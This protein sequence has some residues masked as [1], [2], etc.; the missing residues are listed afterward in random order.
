M[1]QKLQLLEDIFVQLNENQ[2]VADRTEFITDW[3]EREE[4]Y[5]RVLRSKNRDP[6]DTIFLNCADVLDRYAAAYQSSRIKSVRDVGDQLEVL[7]K[8]CKSI[9]DQGKIDQSTARPLPDKS[10]ARAQ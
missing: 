1:N 8:R 9:I 10:A 4:S 2:I 5:L 3:L 7:S 6:S